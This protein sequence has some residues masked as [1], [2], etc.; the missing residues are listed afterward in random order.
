[1]WGEMLGLGPVLK[2]VADPAFGEQIKGFLMAMQATHALAAE[3]IVR[4]DRLERKLDLI[5]L[6]LGVDDAH[7]DGVAGRSAIS[8]ER[9]ADGAGRPPLTSRVA[10]DGIERTAPARRLA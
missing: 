3:S 6:A 4:V 8:A 9:G 5:M 2:A 10:D 7:F 1:M